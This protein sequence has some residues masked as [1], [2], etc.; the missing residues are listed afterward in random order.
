MDYLK[1]NFIFLICGFLNTAK[2]ASMKKTIL[3][4]I[5]ALLLASSL[6]MLS[7]GGDGGGGSNAFVGTW[8]TSSLLVSGKQ[9]PA[10]LKFG[11]SD[12]TLTVP[13]LGKTEKGNYSIDSV[14]AY[15]AYLYQNGSIV[16]RADI[17]SG[18]L[19]LNRQTLDFPYNGG[20]FTRQ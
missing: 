4:G 10:T 12:W 19:F 8:S 20:I 2:D 18:S 11:A 15:T 17:S 13:S 6:A 1:R 9:T 5:A 16:A 7:C 3:F 14:S